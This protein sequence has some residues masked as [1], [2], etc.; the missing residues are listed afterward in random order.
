[1]DI[2]IYRRHSAGCEQKADRYAPRCG[3]PLA[4]QF[5]WKQASTTLDGKKLKRG[6]N[7]WAANTRSWSE[8]QTKA[9]NLEKD[10]EN[11]LQGKTVRHGVT[12][13]A[14]INEWM[15]FREKNGLTNTKPKLMGQKLT[16]WCEKNEILLL[17]AI[18]TDRVMKFRMSLPFRTGDSSSLK[19]HWAVI[20]GFFNWA[21]GM[22][23]IDKN[24]ILTSRQNP[25]FAIRYDKKEVKPPTKKQIEKVLATASGRVKLL[26][27]LMRETAMA[28]VD[29]QKFD[30]ATLE[31]RTL[32]RNNRHKTHERFR[33]RISSTLAKQLEALGSP[34]FPGTDREWRERLYKVFRAAGVKMTP[35]GFRHF[36]ISEWLAHG[37]SVAD[38]SK[39]VGTSEKEIRKTYEHWIKEAEDR[40][41]EVQKQAWLAQG[42]DENGN[43]KERLFQ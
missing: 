26:A 39:W 20:N 38:V 34:A 3:C 28:L 29:A 42:L 7:K 9:K 30:P 11:L 17:T 10:L 15:E 1:M 35:H 33:V 12:V 40:L 24:P 4:F 18:T 16:D 31:D 23:Y 36:R 8:A 37:V 43:Q 14:A 21:Q 13:E 27:Q 22:G 25:Q 19:V 5:N 2:T 41:D 6:Q 32:I